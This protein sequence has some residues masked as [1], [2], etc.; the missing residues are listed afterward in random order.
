MGLLPSRGTDDQQVS[1]AYKLYKEE[2]LTECA[3]F[4]KENFSTH[5]EIEFVGVWYAS[6]ST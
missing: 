1:M 4:K 6:F 3:T 5:V 2:K